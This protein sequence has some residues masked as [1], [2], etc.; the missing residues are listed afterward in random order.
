[1]SNQGLANSSDYFGPSFAE[2]FTFVFA[3]FS[4]ETIFVSLTVVCFA[5]DSFR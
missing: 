5:L 4:R 2:R 3:C 1:M